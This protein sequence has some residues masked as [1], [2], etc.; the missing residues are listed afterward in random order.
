MA[1]SKRSAGSK[2]PGKTKFK[3]PAA[4]N[5]TEVSK[6]IAICWKAGTDAAERAALLKENGLELATAD[7]DKKSGLLRVNQTSRLT[8]ACGK[9]GKNLSASKTER[10]SGSDFVDWV[11]PCFRAE[12]NEAAPASLFAVN[13]TRLY[14]RRKA[15]DDAGGMA[16]LDATLSPDESRSLNLGGL[17]ALRVA[18]ANAIDAAARINKALTKSGAGDQVRFETIPFLS[19]TCHA[20]NCSPPTSEYN[21]NDPMFANQ[22]G[23]QRIGVPRA[24]Q[25]TQGSPS[26]TVAVIDEGVQLN[27]PDLLLHPNSWNASDDTADGSPTGNHGTACAGI[28]AASIDNSQ[29]VAG[30]AGG[31]QI[32]A[33][34]T[35]TWAD[36]DIVEGLYF[37]ADNGARVVSMSFGVYESW[38]FWDLDLI[39]DALQYASDKGLLLVAA[40]GNENGNVS[41]FPGSDSRTLCVGGTNRSDERKRIGDSSSENWWGASFG[42]DVDVCAPCLEIPTTDRLGGD[43][44][45]P[46][47]YF[48][49]FN[50]TSSA[51]PHVAGL[52]AL[53]FSMAPSLTSAE[54]RA[55]IERT[56]DK[57]SPATYNYANVPTKPSGTWNEEVGY[58]RVNA[59]RALLEVCSLGKTKEKDCSSCDGCGDCCVEERNPVC[60]G[61]TPVPWQPHDRCQYFYEGRVFPL[62][63][64]DFRIEI[65]VIYQHCLKLKGR[66]QGPLL[67]TTTLLPGEKVRVFEFDRYRRIR[68][69][70]QRVSVSTSFR[71]TLSS[72]SQTRRARSATAYTNFL[73]EVRTEADTSISA[74]GGLAGFLGAPNVSGSFEVDTE[75]TIASGASVRTASEQFSQLAITASQ[76]MEAERS[77]T[78]SSFEDEEHRTTTSRTLKN[79]NKCHAVTYFVRRVNELYETSTRIESV[80][81]R[82]GNNSPW[83]S[84][85]DLAGL[86]ENLRKIFEQIGKVIP[87]KGDFT[88]DP[89]P[90]TLPTDGTLYE[91]ELA[92]CSS[93]EPAMEAMQKVKLE[94]ERIRARR[95]CLETELLEL[96]LARRKALLASGEAES[97]AV[98][99]WN[100]DIMNPVETAVQKMPDGDI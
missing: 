1:Q 55:I 45:D 24:W 9:D 5:C 64:N 96:E 67:Y 33:I 18:D 19:P 71:Q 58:G 82:Q 77:L 81:W 54:A 39:R 30:V 29:G 56:C 100:W 49:R 16:S 42:P 89:R 22:W 12:S 48:D 23:L 20:V 32:M 73:N 90:I 46:G 83:R 61:P 53:L 95:S 36:I 50:G 69:A 88:I 86:P 62:P 76:A 47:D 65:R 99:E 31:S 74:G 2:G 97:L 26:V 92:H 78:V 87:K 13:P 17:V 75:T 11:A 37:A 44:Y 68:S 57:V 43:G 52:G 59:E 38:G 41:R 40:S 28:V 10:V 14:A 7:G 60:S 63:I 6:Y 35:A 94:K 51:T 85:D 98:A 8:W 84:F 21:P 3:H 34:A 4:G 70:E 72:L 80:E 93:C 27:H 25:I 91:A 66:Q 79:H 15:L